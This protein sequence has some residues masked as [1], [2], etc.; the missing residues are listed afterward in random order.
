M[1]KSSIQG[2]FIPSYAGVNRCGYVVAVAK[3]EYIKPNKNKD[4]Y[5]NDI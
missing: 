4:I 5:G 1:P 2:E 3:T